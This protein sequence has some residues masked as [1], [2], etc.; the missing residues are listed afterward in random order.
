MICSVTSDSPMCKRGLSWSH[1]ISRS[2][3][4]SRLYILRFQGSIEYLLSF[5][6]DPIMKMSFPD[7]PQPRLFKHKS[8][9]H[10]QARYTTDPPPVS[11]FLSVFHFT[12]RSTSRS[13]S[14]HCLLVLFPLSRFH[15][16]PKSQG[17]HNRGSLKAGLNDSHISFPGTLCRTIAA[18]SQIALVEATKKMWA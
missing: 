14:I 7:V 10:E 1:E 6:D 17:N 2:D 9:P 4:V 13:K 12:H 8:T 5:C 18:T 16:K 15:P 11:I 3:I